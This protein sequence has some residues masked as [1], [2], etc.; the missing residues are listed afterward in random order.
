MTGWSIGYVFGPA[1]FIG[2]VMKVHDATVAGAPRIA[3]IGALHALDVPEAELTAEVDTI[4][5]R[6]DVMCEELDK[7]S[8]LF[9]YVRPTGAYYV[10]PKIVAQGW[11]DQ[12]LARALVD[13]AHVVVIPGFTF[14]PESKNH[15]RFCFTESED[16]IREGFARIAQWWNSQ[17]S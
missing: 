2:E 3:Q 11:D 15:V 7:L 17:K 4:Q 5:K 1:A 6:R 8:D 16:V 9:S 14:G 10:F 12:K 13:E